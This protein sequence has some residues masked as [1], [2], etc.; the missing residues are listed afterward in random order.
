MK[1]KILFI[2]WALLFSLN[3]SLAQDTAQL[4]LFYGETCAH[5][6]AEEWY[7]QGLKDEY[8]FEVI[9]YEVYYHEENLQKMQEYAD[10]FWTTFNG[11]PVIIMW[12]DYFLWASYNKTVALLEKYATKKEKS[13]CQP[14]NNEEIQNTNPIVD[15]TSGNITN[16]WSITNTW[17]T[18]IDTTTWSVI[19][20][21]SMGE[22]WDVI[23]ILNLVNSWNVAETWNI[24]DNEN[25]NQ[26]TKIFWKEI[27]LEKAGP[28]LFWVILWLADWINPCMFWVLIFLLTYLISIWSRKKVLY[29]GL[30]FALTT[31]VLY[32]AIMYGMYKLIFSTMMFMPYIPIIKYIIWWLAIILWL[33]EIK[34]FFWYGKWFSLAIPKSVKPTLEYITKKW[35]YMS[36]FVLA[37]LSTFVELPCTIWIPLAYVWAVGTKMNIFAALGIYNF[38]FILPLIFVILWIYYW[39][40]LFKTKDGDLAINKVENKKIM[41]LIAGIILITLGI[42]FLTRVL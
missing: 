27:S 42:L 26:T 16:S 3:F 36:A 19:E 34:D 21:W 10:K 39:I 17:N 28:V 40:A 29:S 25:E 7:L 31:F 14:E 5:C 38:F 23:E 33:I 24:I 4:I 30:I 41:R 32:F 1:K 9:G 37:V 11:V 2:L 35:T 12:D 18:A 8:D 20:T 22:N 15:C 6:K 13:E